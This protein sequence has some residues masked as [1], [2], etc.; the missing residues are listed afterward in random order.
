MGAAT[1]KIDKY[2][3]KLTS[4]TYYRP[5]NKALTPEVAKQKALE[6]LQKL[7]GEQAKMYKFQNI[8]SSTFSWVGSEKQTSSVVVFS[9]PGKSEE[10]MIGVTGNGEI[11]SIV[12]MSA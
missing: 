9:G 10:L 6:F 4:L 8:N 7:Y 2:S 11:Y 3:G 5:S 12:Q 1:F